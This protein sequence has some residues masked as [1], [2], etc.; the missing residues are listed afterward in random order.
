GIKEKYQAYFINEVPLEMAG[1]TLKPGA[2]GVGFI[3]G[4][5]FIVMDIAANDVFQVGS[6]KDSDMKRPVP[7]QITASGEGNYRLYHGRDYVEFHRP[8]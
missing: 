7:L 4:N 5:K 3:D 2:Y 1:Q 6:T 8:K